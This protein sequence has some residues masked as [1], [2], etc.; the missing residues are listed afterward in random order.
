[1]DCCENKNIIKKKEMYFCK[2]YRVI[3]GYSWTE[4]DFKFMNIMRIFIT[5]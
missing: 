3:H 4:Y 1:M 2:N 5:Y